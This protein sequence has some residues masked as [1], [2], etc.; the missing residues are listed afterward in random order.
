M[1]LETWCGYCREVFSSLD[2]RPTINR[3][4]PLGW[5]RK[6]VELDMLT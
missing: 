2:I 6:Q 3:T 5:Q 4:V 1:D